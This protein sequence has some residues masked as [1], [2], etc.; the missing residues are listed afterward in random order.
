M[1]KISVYCQMCEK[2]IIHY[3]YDLREVQFLCS[4]CC[5]TDD[6]LYALM[7]GLDTCK[8]LKPPNDYTNDENVIIE[9]DFY[10]YDCK[11]VVPHTLSR[12]QL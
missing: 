8:P 3:C 2:E 6:T 9:G 5:G 4:E 7:R 12:L 1:V 11:D 10:C